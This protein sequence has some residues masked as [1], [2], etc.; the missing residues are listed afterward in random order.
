M[1]NLEIK[2]LS[3]SFGEQCIL[4]DF[5]YSFPEKGLFLL[6]GESGRGKTTLLRIIAGID[7]DYAGEIIS[8]AVSYLFQDKRLFP[9]LTAL[10]NVMIVLDKHNA[11]KMVL[12]E[13]AKALLKRLQ[14]S[15][16]DMKK[17][18]RELSGGMQ[19]RVAIARAIFYDA[20]VL[21]LDEPTKELDPQNRDILLEL[22]QNEAQRRLVILVTHD[23]E[24]GEIP[25][26]NIIY[27]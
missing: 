20:P 24:Y 7:T 21:L 3:K 16:Q 15:P 27:M 10:D 4:A 8:P 1:C 13:R 6:K 22:I 11:D 14:F 17:Y 25:S 5:S 12:L 26:E 19:Q 18:P 2:G 23:D 9:T